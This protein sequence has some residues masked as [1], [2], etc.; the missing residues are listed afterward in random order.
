MY[1]MYCTSLLWDQRP[2]SQ[3]KHW[4]L[5]QRKRSDLFRFWLK[6]VPMFT[7]MLWFPFPLVSYCI[8]FSGIKMQVCKCYTWINNIQQ[9]GKRKGGR[10]FFSQ[11]EPNWPLPYSTVPVPLLRDVR[12]AG[13]VNSF[14]MCAEYNAESPKQDNKRFISQVK[15]KYIA[16]LSIIYLW[17]RLIRT[18]PSSPFTVDINSTVY[19]KPEDCLCLCNTLLRSG[20]RQNKK[21]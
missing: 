13:W 4:C 10:L 14:S 21:F 19:S 9:D 11:I 8:F 12:P 20:L 17:Q 3:L 16:D 1:T 18:T 2:C 5:R 7:K 6:Y 15:T